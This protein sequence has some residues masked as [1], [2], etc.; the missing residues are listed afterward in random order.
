MNDLDGVITDD[1][2]MRPLAA[3]EYNQ[4]ASEAEGHNQAMD[5]RRPQTTEE[6]PVQQPPYIQEN[7]VPKDSETV[8]S[9]SGTYRRTNSRFKGATVYQ[10]GDGNYYH[11]DTL[12][13]GKGAE[14][15]TYD[16]QGNHTGTITP[17]GQPKD[18]PVS[19]RTLPDWA[20]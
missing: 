2:D 16:S 19:G 6:A 12:H 8:L 3:D 20:R 10:D 15:E 18:G 17:D 5:Q 7:R 11:R 13:T 4:I 1:P 9:D 14:I